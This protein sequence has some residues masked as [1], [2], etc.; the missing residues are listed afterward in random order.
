MLY[1]YLQ[2]VISE[3]TLKKKII[4][5]GILKVIDEKRRI[6]SRIRI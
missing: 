6:W 1:M 3:K 2:N 4:F 5:V